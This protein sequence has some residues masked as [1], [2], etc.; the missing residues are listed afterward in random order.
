[1]HNYH[2]YDGDRSK[3]IQTAFKAVIEAKE[4]LEQQIATERF[5][6]SASMMAIEGGDE[7]GD[8]SIEKKFGEQKQKVQSWVDHAVKLALTNVRDPEHLVKLVKLAKRKKE[9]KV[10]CISLLARV[11]S[12]R[13]AR[14]R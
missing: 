3:V 4:A 2:Q 6:K 1:M 8:H 10:H 11:V 14:V 13:V 7:G 5:N 9:I 12:C